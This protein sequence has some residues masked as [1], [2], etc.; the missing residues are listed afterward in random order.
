M[1][2]L[3]ILAACTAMFATACSNDED[4]VNGGFDGRRNIVIDPV[5]MKM[6]ETIDTRATDIDFEKGDAIGLN[7]KMADD[8]SEY[9]RNG[10]LVFDGTQFKAE[11]E[12]LWYED[13]GLKSNLVAYYPYTATLPAEFTVKSDQSV[14]TNYTASDLMMGF[15]EGVFPTDRQVILPFKHMLTKLVVNINNKSYGEI[16]SVTFKGTVPTAAVDFAT[17]TIAV[18]E[19]VATQDVIAKKVAAQGG[20]LN[21]AAIVV[22]QNVKLQM[23]VTIAFNGTEKEMVQTYKQVELKNGQYVVTIDVL[24]DKIDIV[25][26]GDIQDWTDNGTLEPDQPVNPEPQPEEDF[27]EFADHFIYHGEKY[28][29]KKFADGRVW[30]TENLRYVPAGVTVSSDPIKD[31]HMWYPYHVENAVCIADT[32][33]A[34]VAKVGYLYDHEIALNGGQPIT[35]ENARTFEGAQGIC[36]KGWHI[37]TSKEYGDLFGYVQKDK[38]GNEYTNPNAPFYDED[39]KGARHSSVNKAG[40]NIARPGTRFKSSSETAV[41]NYQKVVASDGL[42]GLTYYMCS[43]YYKTHVGKTSTN[44]QFFGLMTSMIAKYADDGRLHV[45]YNNY[46]NGV[47]VRCIK[48]A[49]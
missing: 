37:P 27:Q 31:A 1:K 42:P 13:A 49:K 11:S 32:D 35:D 7:I 14:A 33:A 22:P 21:F 17:K 24:P 40:W 4:L 48:D 44:M 29:I 20:Q 12:M 6:G 30:M 3:W 46:K 10:K 2:K 25:M 34:A 5:I 15:K 41:G 39:W 36:P 38:D 47:A 16:K 45:A 9:L 23:A 19:G 26:S 43:T 8:Q 18:K 28:N